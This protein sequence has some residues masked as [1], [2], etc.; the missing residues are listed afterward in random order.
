[1][2]SLNFLHKSVDRKTLCLSFFSCP[3]LGIPQRLAWFFTS[4]HVKPQIWLN[5]LFTALY[6]SPKGVF[7]LKCEQI[8][9]SFLLNNDTYLVEAKW[10]SSKTGNA[11]PHAFH[12]KLDQKI[13]WAR[14]VG[15]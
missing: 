3:L 6:L 14:G 15:V 5:E 12:G 7:R 13:S 4:L 2:N 10:H 8:D 1:M 9:G 11:D